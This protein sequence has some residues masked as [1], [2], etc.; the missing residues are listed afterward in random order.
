MKNIRE[1]SQDILSYI[2]DIK[3][4]S[5]RWQLQTYEQR[6]QLKMA[7]ALS[8]KT[9]QDRLKKQQQALENELAQLK[10]KHKTELT[11]LKLKGKQDIKDYRDYLN[12][13]EQLKTTITGQYKRLPEALAFTIHHHAKQLLNE[14]WEAQDLQHKITTELRLIEFMTSINEDI[15][16]VEANNAQ[17]LPKKT[18]AILNKL[19]D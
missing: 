9:L 18:L 13:L 6:M 2:H 10:E 19:L 8:E 4:Q 7:Q 3:K 16:T 15:Q 11:L 5:L 17:V 1:W 14:M 12:A